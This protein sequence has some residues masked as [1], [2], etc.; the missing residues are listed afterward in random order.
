[1]WFKCIKTF[2]RR[3]NI[4]D[5]WI[6]TSRRLDRFQLQNYNQWAQHFL[7]GGSKNY[8][9]RSLAVCTSKRMEKCAKLNNFLNTSWLF[10]LWLNREFAFRSE[11]ERR[12]QKIN[13]RVCR[14]ILF[15]A[16]KIRIVRRPINVMS[17]EL[18]NANLSLQITGTILIETWRNTND[19]SCF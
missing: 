1:M 11:S 2:R 6:I 10:N 18:N 3:V 14:F 7:E 15:A 16:K 5:K 19:G 17:L 8:K 13:F 4:E 9:I 12:R